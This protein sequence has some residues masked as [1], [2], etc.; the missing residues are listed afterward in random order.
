MR[1]ES[2]LVFLVVLLLAGALTAGCASTSK[3]AAPSP[4]GEWSYFIPNTPQGDV[5]GTIMVA[6]EDDAYSG[7]MYIDILDQTFPIED[8]TFTDSTFSFKALLEA[9]GQII[10]TVT[11][12]TLN[13]NTMKGTMDV[14]GLGEMEITATRKEMEGGS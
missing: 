14:E 7:E 9:N 8:V 6:L 2:Y 13:G 12:M 1:R 10:G 3:M 4:V 5:R 11:S